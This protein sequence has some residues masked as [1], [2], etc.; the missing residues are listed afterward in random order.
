MGRGSIGQTDVF[1][2][3]ISALIRA[4]LAERGEGYRWLA[5]GTGLSLNY[6]G[7]RL[8]DK[9]PFNM[10]DIEKIANALGADPFELM[11]AASRPRLTV[12]PAADTDL[13]DTIRNIEDARELGLNTETPYAADEPRN[14]TPGESDGDQPGGEL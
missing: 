1:G 12:V 4:E 7:T 11:K 6:I 3:R 9:A 5:A 8:A 10:N 14:T 2:Q 13:T